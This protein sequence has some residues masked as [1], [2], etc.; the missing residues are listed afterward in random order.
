M[1]V[2]LQVKISATHLIQAASRTHYKFTDIRCN[3]KSLYW[4]MI[5]NPGYEFEMEMEIM[6]PV[7]ITVCRIPVLLTVAKGKRTR[8]FDKMTWSIHLKR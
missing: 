3:G 5:T 8:R 4:L 2:A 7:H 1:S 6:S